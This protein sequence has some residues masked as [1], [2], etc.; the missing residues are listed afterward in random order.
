M[1]EWICENGFVDQ[2][3]LLVVETRGRKSNGAIAVPK[4][5]LIF[6]AA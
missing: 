3:R 5:E 6:T 1:M 2:K 4:C